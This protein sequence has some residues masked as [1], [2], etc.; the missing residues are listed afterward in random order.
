M[1][2]KKEI[3]AIVFALVPLF[4]QAYDTMTNIKKS[5]GLNYI[6]QRNTIPHNAYYAFPPIFS[7]DLALITHMGSYMNWNEPEISYHLSLSFNTQRFLWPGLGHFR[8]NE[9]YFCPY[10]TLPLLTRTGLKARFAIN[11]NLGLHMI[12]RGYTSANVPR[13]YFMKGEFRDALGSGFG[14]EYQH[15]ISNRGKLRVAFSQSI[16]QYF[17]KQIEGY[18]SPYA[19]SLSYVFDKKKKLKSS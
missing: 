18:F 4:T 19:V 16:M 7:A 11:W 15:K 13:D 3:F 14:F 10:I 5:V 1:L 6:Y 8:K 12:V 2:K 9:F 17:P